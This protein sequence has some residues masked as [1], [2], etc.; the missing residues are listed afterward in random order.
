MKS[1]REAWGVQLDIS[2]SLGFALSKMEGHCRVLKDK[3][4]YLIYI[5]KGSLWL[6]CGEPIAGPIVTI[7][8]SNDDG[9]D[10]VGKGVGGQKLLAFVYIV[11]VER[12]VFPDGLRKR[13]LRMLEYWK[14]DISILN[15]GE[16]P[17]WRSRLTEED[18]K[19]SLGSIPFEIFIRRSRGNIK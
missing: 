5:L 1:E 18:R 17:C 13:Q 14:R 4:Q 7:Q 16:E 8:V 6:L 12:K 9:S 11:G 15:W 10:P 2:S 3:W 19:F